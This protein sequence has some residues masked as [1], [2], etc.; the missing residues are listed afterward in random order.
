MKTK[1]II[2]LGALAVAS[3]EEGKFIISIYKKYKFNFCEYMDM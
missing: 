3:L 2:I 1:N